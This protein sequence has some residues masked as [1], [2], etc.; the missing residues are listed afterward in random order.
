MGVQRIFLQQNLCLIAW[1]GTSQWGGVVPLLYSPPLFYLYYVYYFL[2][3][4]IEQHIYLQFIW[5]SKTEQKDF[6]QK[7]YFHSKKHLFKISV[8]LKNIIWLRYWLLEHEL[9]LAV[10]K[11]PVCGSQQLMFFAALQRWRQL[12]STADPASCV[13]GHG[14]KPW[15]A[16]RKVSK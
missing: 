14:R 9:F 8:G 2:N 16:P 13:K 6:I 15:S 1:A 4:N 11:V 5:S 12:R 3:K 7:C 10:A